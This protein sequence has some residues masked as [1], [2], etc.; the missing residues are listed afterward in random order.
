VIA[1]PD[2]DIAAIY[3]QIARAAAIKIANSSLD[4]SSKFPNIV[5]QNS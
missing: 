3:K 5:I 2:G 4:H 1:E